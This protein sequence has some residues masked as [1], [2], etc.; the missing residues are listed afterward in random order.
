MGVALRLC[1]GQGLC[2][3]RRPCNQKADDRQGG[4]IRARR[5]GSGRCGTCCRAGNAPLLLRH[6]PFA[7]YWLARI[8]S[9]VAYAAL[10]V[11]VGWHL[12][13][14]TG[15]ALDLGLLGLVQFVPRS[16]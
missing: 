9:V 8:C 14:L 13:A 1:Y 6:P 15:S 5:R 4:E 2:E 3:S 10:G 12:Y 11:A 7:Y 16:C